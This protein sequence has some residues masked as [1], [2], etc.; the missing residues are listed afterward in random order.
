MP[1][2]DMK[3]LIEKHA[4][5]MVASAKKEAIEVWAP[6]WAATGEYA[7]QTMK[8]FVKS[9]AVESPHWF[10]NA[11][12]IDLHE[13]AFGPKPTLRARGE[14]LNKEGAANYA[15]IAAEWGSDGVSLK[16]GEA[17]AGSGREI[18]KPSAAERLKNPWSREGWNLTKQMG[19]YRD[20]G[21]VG[22]A[23]IAKA[24]GCKIGDTKP[25]ENF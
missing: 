13:Q 8:K 6:L 20:L 1:K 17:P 19:L 9:R 23:G 18:K 11:A 3:A 24:V 4:P 12:M 15:K 22:A 10:P 25:N 2:N 16:P 5:T 7:G 21:P 14:L